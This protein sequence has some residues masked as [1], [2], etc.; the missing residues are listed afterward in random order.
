MA[1]GRVIPAKTY[2]PYDREKGMKGPYPLNKATIRQF[3]DDAYGVYLLVCEG[4]GGG[5]IVIYVGRGLFKD[6]FSEHINEKPDASHFY[7]KPLDD[8]YE[9]FEEECRLFH[10]Y[11]KVNHLDNEMHPPVPA[12]AP[13]N[14]PRC[15]ERGC[16]GEAY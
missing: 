4:K 10:D 2:N 5:I 15:S 11:G 1:A 8:D 7:F 3:E 9:G 14:Y 6:R 13:R 16:K 12:G